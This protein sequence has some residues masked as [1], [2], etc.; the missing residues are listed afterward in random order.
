M[1]LNRD[2]LVVAVVFLLYFVVSFGDGLLMHLLQTLLALAALVLL[3]RAL[4]RRGKKP[5]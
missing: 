1:K 3:V 4:M 2:F 5:E